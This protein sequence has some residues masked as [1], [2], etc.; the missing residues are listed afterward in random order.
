MIKLQLILFFVFS[1]TSHEPQGDFS[2]AKLVFRGVP[3]NTTKEAVIKAF[4]AGKKVDTN[5]ECGGFA[6]DQ[7][8]GPFYQLA[9]D[10]FNYIGSDKTNFY[11]QDVYFDSQGKVQLQYGDIFFSGK[12]TDSEFVKTFGDKAQAGLVKHSGFDTILLYSKGSD[13]AGLFTFKE[14][15]LIKFEYWTPC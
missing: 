10:G 15:R 14:G 8:G 3:F 4:G 5:Y 2:L 11:L 6:N 12:T 13:D 1:A 9:F 7:P